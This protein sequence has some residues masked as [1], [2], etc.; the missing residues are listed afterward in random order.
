MGTKVQVE[1]P[2]G[3]VTVL[4]GDVEGSVKH[5]EADADAMAKSMASLE[6]LLDEVVPA[7]HGVRPLEQ[8]EGDSFVV[9]FAS[10]V[11]AVACATAIQLGLVDSDLRVRMAVHTDEAIVRGTSN[12]SGAVVNRAARLRALAHGGQVLV[13]GTTHELVAGK[14]PAKADLRDRGAHTLRDVPTP[15]HVWQLAHP[16]LADGSPTLRSTNA[17]VTNLPTQ[18]TTFVGR[19]EEVRATRKLLF[20]NRLVSLTGAGG[21]GKTRLSLEL[22]LDAFEA[23][24]H[25]VWFVDQ[26]PVTD[27]G[28]VAVTITAALGLRESNTRDA[29]DVVADHFGDD[30]VLLVLDNCEH[31]V[32]AAASFVDG[33]LRRC[34]NLTIVVTSREPLNVGGEANYAVPPLSLP[35]SDCDAATLVDSDAV[36]LFVDRVKHADAAFEL[37]E[38]SARTIAAICRRVDGLPLAIELA[39]AR[40][41]TL[42]L[43]AIAETLARRFDLLTGGTRTAPARQQS[44]TECVAWSHEL[45]G[46][47]ERTVLR[48]LSVFTGSFATDAADAVCGPETLPTLLALVDKSL[49]RLN[50]D[51]YSLLAVVRE[52]ACDRLRESTDDEDELRGRHL[53][54]LVELAGRSAEGLTGPEHA[55]WLR[56]MRAEEPDIE[57]TLTWA[58]A[59]DQAGGLRLATAL[60]MFNLCSANLLRGWRWVVPFLDAIPSADPQVAA[61]ACFSAALNLLFCGDM[62]L[63]IQ[64]SGFIT[65][66]LARYEA[67]GDAAGAARARGVLALMADALGST[68]DTRAH[69]EACVAEMEAT[70]KDAWSTMMLSTLG[71]YQVQQGRA[72]T[73]MPYLDRARATAERLGHTFVLT[74][75][76]TWRAGAFGFLGEHAKAKAIAEGVLATLAETGHDPDHGSF[77]NCIIAQAYFHSG[78][79]DRAEH[80]AR[81]GAIMGERHD[82]H[83]HAA[84]GYTVLGSVHLEQGRPA[85]AK[86]V[87]EHALEV[88]SNPAFFARYA[89]G[90]AAALMELD[91]LDGAREFVDRGLGMARAAAPSSDLARL[92]LLSATFEER[93]GEDARAEDL[94]H[95]ALSAIVQVGARS[96]GASTLEHLAAIAARQESYLETVRLFAAA[97]VVRSELG[98]RAA[99]DS[100]LDAARVAL[101]PDVFEGAWSEGAAMSLVDA[102]AYAS[103]GRGARKRP[104]S[105]WASL[106]PTE[107]EVVRLV[108]EGLTNPQIGD[109]M[110]ISRGTVRTHLTHVFA[111]LGV[112]SR[113]Q[114]ATEAT[115]RGL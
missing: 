94:L 106:T 98:R 39:A 24:P 103:R 73:A 43:D 22:A 37:N 111:K 30:R 5:W 55:M 33:V 95:E 110:F 99:D 9:A 38:T 64:G 46:D 63:A 87:F 113:A 26:T 96:L 101:E 58:Q 57:A 85:D 62:A 49:V 10:P 79:L 31:V 52:F 47:A 72:L 97:A 11:D 69:A 105:G 60:V 77:M 36:E 75:V 35:E 112:S 107:T 56:R 68:E 76:D 23:Y 41:R 81:I 51:R 29:P 74:M 115:R 90:L 83:Q 7:H 104:S 65:D 21:T 102:A 114:L 48:R 32:G 92:L 16:D 8:G 45:L 53:T 89:G 20:E 17:L 82:I 100:V 59:H 86:L 40:A 34:P 12:Y 1:V 66:A 84:F 80:H 88:N 3:V 27:P 67:I 4:L 71:G 109:R 6:R 2:V 54:F 14:L 61:D 19:V 70:S 108:T 91:D 25:G 15:V 78:D 18:L 44:V 42:S 93:A 50:G 28:D 13:S